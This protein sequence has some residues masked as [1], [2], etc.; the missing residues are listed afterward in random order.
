M[1]LQ[2]TAD[3]IEALSPLTLLYWYCSW[4]LASVRVLFSLSLCLSHPVYFATSRR[5]PHSHRGLKRAFVSNS[6]HLEGVISDKR[7]RPRPPR[8]HQRWAAGRTYVRPLSRASPTD[9]GQSQWW[10][11]A[12]PIS[13]HIVLKRLQVISHWANSSRGR[14]TRSVSWLGTVVVVLFTIVCD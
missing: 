6:E 8:L 1:R 12:S 9:R 2:K 14:M 11:M 4:I 5:P 3:L 7:P 13:D 10:E